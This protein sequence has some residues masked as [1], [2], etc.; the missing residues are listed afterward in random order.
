M[1]ADLYYTEA[2]IIGKNMKLLRLLIKGP[3][4]FIAVLAFFLVSSI[5][6]LVVRD[7][8]TKLA[9][10]SQIA[11]FFAKVALMLLGVKVNLKNMD[12]YVKSNQNYMV[13][14]NHLSY[15]DIFII[16]TAFPAVFIANSELEEEFPLG[17]IT[18]FAGGVFVERRN[19]SRL[20][21]DMENISRVL[22]LGFKTV[23]FPE[24][25]T[26]NG[27]SVLPF[28][29]PF[30]K[31]AINTNTDVLTLCINYKT[32]NG[33]SINKENRDYI[34]YY[35]SV[36]FFDH[37]FRLLTVRSIEVELQAIEEIKVNPDMTRKEL[38]QIAY[39]KISNSYSGI[40]DV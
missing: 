28:K 23:L 32:V 2:S 6:D 11:S 35:E 37:F 5:A 27:E 8:K 3:L 7:K 24:A 30:L 12:K 9:T 14:S 10:F 29:A 17:A 26:S 13:V 15:V 38:S 19:R 22:E 1:I 21:K 25:T 33:I 31:S 39:E 4:F 18:K 16:Y 34:F 36:A 20:L 40:S